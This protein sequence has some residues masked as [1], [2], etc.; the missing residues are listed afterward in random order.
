MLF[1]IVLAN[2]VGEVGVEIIGIEVFVHFV[3]F[4]A[5]FFIC[6]EALAG[7]FLFVD[8]EEV[9]IAPDAA[10]ILGW[11]F[12]FAF[13]EGDEWFVFFVVAYRGEFHIVIPGVAKVVFPFDGLTFFCEEV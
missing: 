2:E 11:A 5:V 10:T 6:G 4:E 13:D 12:T 1:A 9:L 8:T 3:P 7:F